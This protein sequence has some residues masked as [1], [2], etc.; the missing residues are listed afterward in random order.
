MNLRLYLISRG[1]IWQQIE[2]YNKLI[3]YQ[4][5]SILKKIENE[6][7]NYNSFLEIK[8][9]NTSMSIG[10]FFEKNIGNTVTPFHSRIK[11]TTYSIDIYS[12][13]FIRINN[14]K[15][16]INNNLI[17]KIPLMLKCNRCILYGKK[18]DFYI[19]INECPLD[20]GGYFIIKG[21]EKVILIQ[22][23]LVLNRIGIEKDK[24]GNFYSYVISSYKKRN[25][26][27]FI[28][29]KENKI[30]FRNK[31]FIEDIPIF[32]ILKAFGFENNLDI[33]DLIGY[34]FESTLFYS[35]TESLKIGF[36]NQF[37][38]VC[39]LMQKL[40][41]R[42]IETNKITFF[43]NESNYQILDHILS[44]IIVNKN[45]VSQNLEKGI[46]MTMMIRKLLYALQ[47][48]DLLDSKDYYGNKRLEL[49]GDLVE[50]LLE[51]LLHK[52]WIESKKFIEKK[53]IEVNETIYHHFIKSD[54]ISY[55]IENAF[56]TGNW[57]INKYG[58]DKNG[59]TQILS[60]LSFMSS[61]SMLLKTSS[62]FEKTRKS[63]S[64]RNLHPTQWRFIC[65]SDTPE[66]ESCGL[67]KNLA[68]LSHISIQENDYFLAKVC[69]ILGVD[70]KLSSI[71][72]IK[73]YLNMTKIFLNQKL[74]GFH[75][76]PSKFLFC[77]RNM[78]RSNLIE[79]SVSIYWD[80]TMKLIWILSD[81][82]RLCR[83][84]Y[85]IENGILK[86]KKKHLK[87]YSKK[88]IN[89]NILTKFGFIEYIDSNEEN[90]TIIADSLKA[91]NF[92]SSHLEISE[93]N[94]L[95]ISASLI[96]F[97]D[98]NQSPRN[99]YQCSMGKQ[100]AS[101]LGFNQNS[102]IDITL[103]LLIYP[104][105]PILKT[106]ILN[107]IGAGK[108]PTGI[109]TCISIMSFTGYDVEDA[110][111]LN[112]S[113]V[114]RG[115]FKTAFLRKTKIEI[116][117]FR[118]LTQLFSKVN[119]N[120]KEVFEF[121]NKSNNN[122]QKITSNLKYSDNLVVV[123]Y[124][125]DLTLAKFLIRECRNPEIGDKF[126]SRHGQ[127][128]ICG[129]I[130][131]QQDMPFSEKGICPDIIM[132]PHGFP[133]RMTIGKTIEIILSKSG[134][135][136][137][138]FK[139]GS[140]FKKININTIVKSLRSFG[141]VSNG[142]DFMYN[143]ITGNLIN[144]QIYSGIVFYQRLKHMVKDKIHSRATGIKSKL[145]YQPVEGRSKGGGLRFGEMERDCLISFGASELAL[146]R[147]LLNSDCYEAKFD[148]NSGIIHTSNSNTNVVAVKIPYA[149]KLLLQELQSMNI[150]ARLNFNN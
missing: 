55:G 137:G 80:S 20:P 133:S 92:R 48:P 59:I 122:N 97:S 13:L 6:I 9:I 124:G 60:R 8:F 114:E 139:D 41:I 123:K 145:T 87:L 144:N 17:F 106:K 38:S 18:E 98:H 3:N 71:K 68:L 26:K 44:H 19:K 30:Y 31:I 90:N 150:I 23:K 51:D 129:F 111:I 10:T 138:K 142:E 134:C 25:T 99:T 73:N 117:S 121:L 34:E 135:I 50:I 70:S 69:N 86:S 131:P 143:G 95:G 113:S 54:F 127:K 52:S 108:C 107:L 66:G 27:S 65:T 56:I 42:F 103:S 132:N 37:Q 141:F 61:F 14:K 84:L 22:E 12:D 147:L 76:F 77:F 28:I 119:H 79:S 75:Q 4:L 112:K 53:K 125:L 136:S 94:I 2:S 57:K 120:N 89:W 47:I 101:F 32:I 40:D 109:N 128:G 140:I 81:K 102:R 82:G 33:I 46:F 110:I 64:P 74:I 36:V 1:L 35:L 146:D 7:W 63:I 93:G 58:I 62:N 115:F 116:S 39:Y 148:K 85:I 15:K 45:P 16:F 78:R 100:S 105:K 91:I 149:C 43:Y 21:T 24:S 96:P 130:K 104:Q 83:P 5:I 126:S 118:H 67:I 88:I 29:I 49:S 11:D 72:T